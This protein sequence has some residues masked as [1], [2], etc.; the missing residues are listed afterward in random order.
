MPNPYAS[1]YPYSH[2]PYYNPYAY[3]PYYYGQRDYASKTAS[4]PP[5]PPPMPAPSHSLFPSPPAE[6]A[7]LKIHSK[8][9]E[10]A[11]KE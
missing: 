7:S 8:P 5:P 1:Y 11:V 3:P 10:K 2:Y 6:P 4:S 9:Q